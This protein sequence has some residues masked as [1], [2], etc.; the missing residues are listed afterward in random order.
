MNLVSFG[1]DQAMSRCGVLALSASGCD[2][3]RTNILL[4]RG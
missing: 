2:L 1:R 3:H 4:G